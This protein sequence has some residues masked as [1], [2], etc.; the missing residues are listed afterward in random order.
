[1]NKGYSQNDPQIKEGM[2]KSWEKFNRLPE[3]ERPKTYA[4]PEKEREFIKQAS[5][6]FH[7]KSRDS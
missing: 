7:K 2:K 5:I 6:V 1:M 4:I 3:N